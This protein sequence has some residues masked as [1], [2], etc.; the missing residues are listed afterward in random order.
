[1]ILVCRGCYLPALSTITYPLSMC[2]EV[3][4]LQHA[5][6]CFIP[7]DYYFDM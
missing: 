6:K 1:M 4:I 5:G 3:E 2:M 7:E